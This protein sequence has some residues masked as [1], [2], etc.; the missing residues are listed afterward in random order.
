MELSDLTIQRTVGARA[1]VAGMSYA[2]SGRVVDLDLTTGGRLVY[3]LVQ[4][5]GSRSYSVVITTAGDGWSG[6]CSCPVGSACKHVAAVMIAAQ[7]EPNEPRQASWEGPLAS[8]VRA[9]TSPPQPTGTPM[10]LQLE[11]VTGGRVRLRPVVP[12]RTGNWVRTGASWTT[13]G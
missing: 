10:A 5:S 7:G 12:G 11:V 4:G 2:R 13:R 3:G 6:Q 8:V 1:F 9:R